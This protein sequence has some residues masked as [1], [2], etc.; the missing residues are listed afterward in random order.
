MNDHEARRESV[1]AEPSAAAVTFVTT[2]HFTLQ[3][4]R[5]STVAEATGRASMFLSAVSGGLVA[6]GLIATASGVKAPSK[7]SPSSC[8]Q[9]WHW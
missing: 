9:D 3:G 2:G 6:L 4:A 7:S 8:Y 5:A 1:T